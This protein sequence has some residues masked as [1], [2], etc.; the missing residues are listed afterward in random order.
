MTPTEYMYEAIKTRSN[1]WCD[2]RCAD[3]IHLLHAA[4]GMATESGEML[5][6]LKKT[7]FYGKPLDKVNIKEEIGDLLWYVAVAC[8][9]LHT[10]MEDI[11]EIN[12]AKL[13]ARYPEKF[14][15]QEALQRNIPLERAIL[16]MGGG[17]KNAK[18]IHEDE[19]QNDERVW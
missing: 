10:P 5:D 18:S 9:A 16:E 2:P 19:K 3:D 15:T 17:D 12:I 8:A 7:M 1:V 13:K 6:A 14:T 4:I 11:M